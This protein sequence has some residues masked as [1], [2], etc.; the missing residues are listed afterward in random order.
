M[1]EQIDLFSFTM[2]TLKI[3]KPIR[4]IELFAGIG[5]QAA[6]LRNLGAD[7]EHYR[8][9][10][11]DRFCVASYNAVHG[12]N[13]EPMDITKVHAEDLGITERERFTYIMCYSFPCQ[14]LSLAGKG[15]G[16][17]K[18]DNTR[19]GLLWEVE[20][21]LDECD[22]LP[23]ILLM[24]NVP[25]VIGKK[26]IKEFQQWRSKLE[27]L[28]YTNHVELLNAKNYGIPQN[29]NRCFMVS[30]LGQY[31]YTFPRKIPLKLKLKDLLEE[32]VDEKYYLSQEMVDS[33]IANSRKQEENGNGFRFEP[34][35]RER[36]QGGSTESNADAG[37]LPERPGGRSL[38]N[39]QAGQT[40]SDIP[41]RIG[42]V[43]KGTGE[44]QS[45]VVHSKDGIAPVIDASAWKQPAKII[46]GKREKQR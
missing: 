14:D 26:N 21:I 34:L 9:V 33:F 22:E 44:H 2:P 10:E 39:E 4:L 13:F 19:S 20:R 17:R 28:G 42:Y 45:N 27:S 29:R 35:E 8:V 40:R 12:T 32:N 18:G 36:E 1:N 16:M 5:S 46:D 3:T 30:V 15:A 6:A 38:N 24:E 31:H 37:E 43:E 41:E 25:Q 7:F 23:Q 11:W